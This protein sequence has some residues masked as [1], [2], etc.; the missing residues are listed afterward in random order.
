MP[1]EMKNNLLAAAF[2]LAASFACLTP[3]MRAAELSDARARYAEGEFKQAA[4][5]FEQFLESSAPQA[6]VYYELGR[7]FRLSGQD[8]RAALSFR[9]A[10]VLDPRFAPARAALQETDADLAIPR[11]SPGWKQR[12]VERVP[13]EGLAL[14]GTLLTWAAA[15]VLAVLLLRR[16]P[17]GRP[18]L[19][20][21]VAALLFG[22]AAITLAWICDPRISERNDAMVLATGGTTLLAAPADQSEKIAALPE[23]AIVKILSQRGRWFYGQTGSGQRGWFLTEGIVPVIPPA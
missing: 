15:F 9:R 14:V 23:G 4:K 20:L 6:A 8:A 18:M 19:A 11:V 3:S 13:L 10:L 2:C 16:A 1:S 17:A 21:G 7:S 5:L 22:A 12:V